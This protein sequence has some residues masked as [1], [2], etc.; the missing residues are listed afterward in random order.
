MIGTVLVCSIVVASGWMQFKQK[1]VTARSVAAC[2]EWSNENYGKGMV[3][4]WERFDLTIPNDLKNFEVKC[5]PDG[6]DCLH[7]EPR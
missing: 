5:G 4:Y 2:H 1:M 3:A 6:I 7:T